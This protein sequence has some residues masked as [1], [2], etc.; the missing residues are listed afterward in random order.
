MHNVVLFKLVLFKHDSSSYLKC[1]FYLRLKHVF[2]LVEIG[3]RLGAE[4]LCKSETLFTADQL[5][6]K[7]FSRVF[8]NSMLKA[9]ANYPDDTTFYG[10]F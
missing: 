7:I 4:L 1:F 10:W 9:K 3:S 8:A 6:C 2:I 5:P